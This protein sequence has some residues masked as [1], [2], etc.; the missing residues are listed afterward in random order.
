M[1]V[2]VESNFLLELV[3][4]QEEADACES[5]LKLAE[6]GQISLVV[7]AY[8]LIE[9]WET[10]DRRKTGWKVLREQAFNNRLISEFN[11][12]PLTKAAAAKLKDAS[13]GFLKAEQDLADG[14][15]V[16][17]ARVHE[18]AEL[19]PID[20]KIVAAAERD[21]ATFD[22]DFPDAVMLASVLSHLDANPAAGVFLNRNSNDFDDPAIVAE[23]R[24]RDCKFFPS[25]NGG[26]AHIKRELE[27]VV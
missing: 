2:Y 22:L 4:Q 17:W 8:A 13:D 11:R 18:H 25:F 27:I 20:G 3:L 9:S 26:L 23:L 15:E 24:R 19:I 16:V 12:S 6:C 21:H 1:R 10:V 5:L 7:P 14:K